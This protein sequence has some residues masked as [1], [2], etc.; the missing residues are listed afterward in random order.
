MP[1][2]PG[3]EGTGSYQVFLMDAI[4]RLTPEA[5]EEGARYDLG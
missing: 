4:S 1:G 5:L 2:C 3:P